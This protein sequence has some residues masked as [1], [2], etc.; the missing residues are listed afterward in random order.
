MKKA[1]SFLAFAYAAVDAYEDNSFNHQKGEWNMKIQSR[2]TRNSTALKS[3]F[4]VAF[5]AVPLLIT[6]CDAAGQ[7]DFYG[8]WVAKGGKDFL[9]INKDAVIA[10]HIYGN[11]SKSKSSIVK[12]EKIKWQ[13]NVLQ[14]NKWQNDDGYNIYTVSEKNEKGT[15]TLSIDA[16]SDLHLINLGFSIAEYK[17]SSA[18]ELNKAI[19]DVKVEDE[20]IAALQG[21]F[22]DPRDGKKYKSVKIGKQTWM[23][24][25]LNYNES[26][27]KCYGDKPANCDKYGRLYDWE[28]AKKA[29]PKGWH[30]PSDDEWGTL[31]QAVNPKCS[32]N[33]TCSGA[34]KKLKANNGWNNNG[35]GTDE[36]GFSALPGGLPSSGG[37]FHDVGNY[38]NWWSASEGNASSAYSRRM[39]CNYEGVDR[40]DINK[41]TLFSVRCLQGENSETKAEKTTEKAVPE[42]KAETIKPSFDC[43]KASTSPEKAICSDADLAELDNQ[44]AKAYSKARSSACKK[45]LQKQQKEWMNERNSCSSNIQCLKNSYKSRIQE[46]EKCQ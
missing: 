23:A 2:N 31:M 44:L 21:S 11:V 28:T 42:N 39:S 43:A 29:C 24:E 27:S 4:Y 3:I 26:G 14:Q 1:I 37:F 25:N 15:I 9:E 19:R 13:R 7:R 18:A 35:N 41:G 34:G 36:F 22:T 6:S 33:G 40:Y 38:G 12:W 8:V 10:T 32:K 30:L 20:R 17:K 16:Y 46:L 45:D 5:I